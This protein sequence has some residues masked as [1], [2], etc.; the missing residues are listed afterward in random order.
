M[1]GHLRIHGIFKGMHQPTKE[2]LDYI[3]RFNN[4]PKCACGCG[5]N[6]NL[7]GRKLQYNLFANDCVNKKRF[8]NPCCPEFYIFAGCSSDEVINNISTTQ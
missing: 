1:L 7:H 5:L 4:N 8:K 3:G 6:V 2:F